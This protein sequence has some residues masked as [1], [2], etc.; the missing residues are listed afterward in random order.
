MVS[1]HRIRFCLWMVTAAFV[2]LSVPGTVKGVEMGT[3]VRK[4]MIA[5]TWYPGD[6]AILK[7]DVESFLKKAPVVDVGG[8]IV[9]MVSPHAGIVYS[10]Q[11]AAFGYR[12]LKP[13]DFD[14]VIL[15]GPSHRVRFKG[16]SIFSGDGF[17]SPLGVI[18]IDRKL[19]EAIVANSGNAV[20]FAPDDKTP[21]NSLEIQVPFLQVAQKGVPFVPV[22][23]GSQDYHTCENLAEAIVKSTGGR[24]VL[25]VASSDFS[26]YHD[27]QAASKMDR[28]ALS[29]IENL[30]V[31]GF[32]SDISG[33]SC[34]AC[35]AGPIVV[36]MLVAQK[37][38]AHGVKVLKY[39]NSG[40]I[41]G[42]KSGVVGYASV[43]FFKGESGQAKSKEKKTVGVDMG[44]SNKEKDTLL[45]IA[46][47]SIE[48][49]LA[50][51]EA[52]DIKV[53][54]ETLKTKMGAF[55]T[56]KKQGQLRGCIG[57]IEGRKPLADTVGEMARAAAFNDPRF[58]PVTAPEMKDITIEISAL[59]PLRQITDVNEI[60]VGKH[61]IYMVK[62]YR[63]GLL[64]PQVATE[65]NWDLTTFLEQTCHKA[66]LPTDAWKDKDTKIYIFSAHVF[67]EAK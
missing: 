42:D 20:S 31:E 12:Q 15:V 6:P 13:G 19:A 48:T 59:T 30:D 34:E 57:F 63:S 29:H 4:P 60:E 3:S 7:R 55:V 23:M 5:G 52:P 61:G 67:G 35:G 56:L 66:G 44:L 18:S 54:S 2:V 21:E 45:K 51:E 17:E 28:R 47:T 53:D 10:G 14:A 58:S 16:A 32:I 49:G 40:D 64:L 24:K 41:T 65:W 22:L 11:V 1:K 26:H 25:V 43:V 8:A 27:Y 62:G 39:A 33:G 9:A 46:R 37:R 50:G 38:D 36:A